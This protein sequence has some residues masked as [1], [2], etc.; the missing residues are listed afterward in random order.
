MS[1]YHNTTLHHLGKTKKNNVFVVNIGAM[2]GVS[3]DDTRGFID[4]YDWYGLFVEPVPYLFERLKQSYKHNTRNIYANAAIG[5]SNGVLKMI[6]IDQE[7]I[8][9]GKVHPCFAGMSAVWPPRNGLAS[10]GDEEVVKTFGKVIEV[11]S[12]TLKHLFDEH[13]IKHVDVLSIDTEGY[14]WK[15]LQQL[16]YCDVK[17]T[18]IRCEYIN[19]EDNEKKEIEAFLDKNNYYYEIVGQN[20]DAVKKEFWDTKDNVAQPV[21]NN[22]TVVTGIWDL[23]REQAGEGFKRP[24]SHYTDRFAELLKTDVNMVIFI[25]EEYEP[26]VW[27][28]RQKH[29]TK[30]FQKPVSYFKKSFD[31]YDLVQKIRRDEKWL[32]QVGWL[33]NSTQATLEMYNPMVMSKMFMLHDASI[34]NPFNTDYFVWVDG[35]ITNTVHQGYFTHDKILDKLPNYLDKFFFISFPYE[36]TTEIHGFEYNAMKKYCR[37]DKVEY[38]CRGGLFG[39]HKKYISQANSTYYHLLM[40]SLS[41]GLMGTEESIFTI[42]SYLEPQVYKRFSITSSGLIST[43]AEHLKN[44]TFEKSNVL[45]TAVYVV[46][47]NSPAQF[48]ALVDSWKRSSDFITNTANYL[49]D[50]STDLTTEPLYKQLC[51]EYNFTH[52]KKDNIGICG[53]RQFAAEHFEKSG[54]KYYIFL[55]DDMM[56]NADNKDFCKN[57]FM[58][59]VPDL[60]NKVHAIMEKNKFDFLKFSFTEFFGDNRTQWAWYNVPQTVREQYWPNYCQLPKTGLDPNAPLTNFKNIRCE[61]GVPYADGE[62]YYCN[63]PQIVSKEGNKKMFLDTKFQYPFEQT[64]MSHMFQMT[65]RGELRGAILLAT[66]INHNRFVH[67]DSKLRKEC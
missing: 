64:L 55:E 21:N 48:Q 56:L 19:L 49:I 44:E 41:E 31:G 33:R 8:D 14:D 22:L 9:S 24:F 61:E 13:N 50:N 16:Q 23:R 58:K 37:S 45:E 3:F 36:T 35:G 54:H 29:N 27:Q 28:H 25:E 39:G 62:I 38:V 10:K 20:I 60:Y 67:Y 63:W 7:A 11:P 26:L 40:S 47:F 17:P 12:I 51:E 52:I 32:G 15:I 59:Y 30:V 66:P 1:L 4:K 65:K 5:T 43:F 42:M 2:D 34:Y 46:G 18:M 57:G 53:G 6:T